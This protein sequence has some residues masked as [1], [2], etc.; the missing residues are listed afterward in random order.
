MKAIMALALIAGFGMVGFSAHA[1]PVK[2]GKEQLSS[3]A[4]GVNPPHGPPPGQV[5]GPPPGQQ[6][7][8][9]PPGQTP[10]PHPGR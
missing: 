8:N 5:G 9:K 3:I 7:P 4:A 1:A 10:N 6:G 2:L